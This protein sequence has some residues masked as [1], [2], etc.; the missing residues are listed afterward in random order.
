VAHACT[1]IPAHFTA[2][3]QFALAAGY[4]AL[5]PLTYIAVGLGTLVQ[6]ILWHIP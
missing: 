2:K 3:H 5:F 1:G 6:S 4:L